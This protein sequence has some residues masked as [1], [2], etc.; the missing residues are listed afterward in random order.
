MEFFEINFYT[1]KSDQL[2]PQT[3]IYSTNTECPTI[4][5]TYFGIPEVQFTWKKPSSDK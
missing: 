3:P 1:A 5:K 4:I 2:W